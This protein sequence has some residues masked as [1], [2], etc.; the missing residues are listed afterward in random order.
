MLGGSAGRGP[1]LWVC[2]GYNRADKI[3]H[4]H[5]F[6]FVLASLRAVYLG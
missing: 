5:F 1:S 3:R 6:L 2:W 4:C